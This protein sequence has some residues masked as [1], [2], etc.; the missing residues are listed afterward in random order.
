MRRQGLVCKVITASLALCALFLGGCGGGGGGV[1]F[2]S[3]ATPI[4]TVSPEGNVQA[5]VYSVSIN[6]P[7]VVTFALSDENGSPLDPSAVLR[8]PS[9]RMR[10]YIAR[11]D[12]N[13]QYV[14]YILDASGLPTYDGSGTNP[15][16]TFA[17]VSPGVYTYTFG[18][19]V[20]SNP[21]FDV[22][23]TH[24]VAIQITRNTTRNGKPF[25]QMANPYLNFRPDG[26][27]VTATR[28]VVSISACNQCHGKLI[29]HGSRIEVA[30]CILCHNAGANKFSTG[31]SLDMKVMIHKIHLGPNL[32]SRAYF[33]TPLF[34]NFSTMTYPVFS[35]EFK[36]N[37]V[38][39]D[40]TKC[41]RKGSDTLGRAYGADVD[42]WKGTPTRTNCITCHDTTSFDGSTT[43]TVD[44]VAGIT[45]TPHSGGPQSSDSGC[46][47]SGCHS[48]TG[49]DYDCLSTKSVT[50]LHAI[51]EKSP[52]NKGIVARVLSASNIGPLKY[53]RVTFQVTDAN[54]NGIA[55]DPGTATPFQSG[56]GSTMVL[57][58]NVQVYFAMKPSTGPDFLNTKPAADPAYFSSSVQ[59]LG[60]NNSGGMVNAN[61]TANGGTLTT[62]DAA[63]G[64]YFINFSTAWRIPSGTTP[65]QVP[66]PLP[67]LSG[68]YANGATV[69]F[70]VQATRSDISV[71]R[72]F[73]STVLG[74]IGTTGG[75]YDPAKS[76]VPVRSILNPVTPAQEMATVY[77]DLATGQPVGQ[78]R[79]KVVDNAKCLACHNII[80]GG[81][82]PVGGAPG[83]HGGARP[84]AESCVLCHGPNKNES[85][86]K[87]LIHRWH[88]GK[89]STGALTGGAS[90]NSRWLASYKGVTYPNDRRRCN[91]CHVADNPA[92]PDPATFFTRQDGSGVGGATGANI[93]SF[94][95][96][97][98]FSS[99]G[100]SGAFLTTVPATN[101]IPAITAAC[102]AC[103]DGTTGT[104]AGAGG[105][106]TGH[107]VAN[108]GTAPDYAEQCSGCHTDPIRQFGHQLPN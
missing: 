46:L 25:Q 43:G 36:A 83:L 70:A 12:A 57:K 42:K 76:T 108:Y 95:F 5:K 102:I 82:N 28:E 73:V 66:T 52:V 107:A 99:T 105:G 8:D 100:G 16:G 44:G 61:F 60:T 40:C 85:D 106:P 69:A 75:A 53:P 4:T 18:A 67:S 54:G 48:A 56:G 6:S 72:R 97:A 32:P 51:W 37:G 64:I 17:T 20:K 87:F 92:L 2:A 49:S 29:A 101:R 26:A 78:Q 80:V 35:S 30:L 86:F 77:Y 21:L 47:T 88:T 15:K 81:P 31:A 45:M 14:N 68:D 27:Q 63:K 33:K 84:N 50:G 96:P 23:K 24:T 10:F 13:G 7:P 91:A 41:H 39:M 38:P 65:V 104:V 94:V 74:V 90:A 79:R 58:N 55:I 34:A 93:S 59:G 9:N 98:G 89:N 22:T 3:Q 11:L 62:V 103:H 71:T 1:F 19:N